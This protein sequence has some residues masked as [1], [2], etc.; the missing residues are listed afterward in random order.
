VIR[1]TGWK[2][3]NFNLEYTKISLNLPGF[4]LT[5][6]LN[7]SGGCSTHTGTQKS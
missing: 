7:K 2:Y 4:L 1:F 3:L 5:F 6:V